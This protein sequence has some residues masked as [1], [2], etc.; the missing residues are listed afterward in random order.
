M[1]LDNWLNQYFYT[2]NYLYRLFGTIVIII[3]LGITIKN[4]L[5]YR[6]LNEETAKTAYRD[7][8]ILQEYFVSLQH[9]YLNQIMAKG[10]ELH[11]NSVD[12][13]PVHTA[14]L[15]SEDFQ[16]RT[17]QGMNIRNISDDNRNPKNTP[18]V[19]EREAIEYFKKYPHKK[20]FFRE[21]RVD[22]KMVYFYA[23]P[24]KIEPFCLMCHGKQEDA[25]A[26]IQ[27]TY[28]TGYN[29]KI[30]DI[31]GITSITIEK[32]KLFE[33]MEAKFKVR[34]IFSLVI[35][36]VTILL[37]FLLVRR[38]KTIETRMTQDLEEM[39]FTDSLTG[40]WNRRKLIELI[41]LYHK[42]FLRYGESYSLIMIDIDNF[43]EVN[44]TYGHPQGDE[45]LKDFSRILRSNCRV[46]DHVGRWGGEEFMFILP[47]TTL[48]QA[49][50]F[51]EGV[52]KRVEEYTFEIIDN[53]TASFGVAEIHPNESIEMLIIRV[54][55]VLYHAKAQGRNR[56]C[57]E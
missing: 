55:T 43:K 14:P 47:N 3:V 21:L 46:T 45:V 12:F 31:R 20:E 48:N 16:T 6:T 56:V 44:D 38:A 32:N 30:G 23:A 24:L 41:E 18:Y 49:A 1:R 53:K 25:P 11:Q 5:E 19:Y 8:E 40:V 29:Y 7:A 27:N 26:Y 52:R 9:V 57:I 34:L 54:D 10:D 4:W 50:I 42:L 22:N 51:A 36:I 28:S 35:V 37:I 2:K 39:S 33:T 15:I 17:T 13:L